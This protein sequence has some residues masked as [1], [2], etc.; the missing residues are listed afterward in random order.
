[1]AEDNREH[2]EK[3]ANQQAYQQGRRDADVD[4]RLLSHD[5]HLNRLDSTFEK[6]EKAIAAFDSKLDQ[7]IKT[8]AVEADRDEQD[9]K[10]AQKLFTRRTLLIAFWTL[11][12]MLTGVIVSVVALALAAH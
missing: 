2:I 1:M 4:A 3:L 5:R 9:D 12:V 7:V 8:Q 6:F 11:V 10:E